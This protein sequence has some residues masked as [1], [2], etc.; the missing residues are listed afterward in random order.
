MWGFGYHQEYQQSL[1]AFSWSRSHANICH[2][3]LDW[4]PA[5]SL[6]ALFW[7]SCFGE[8]ALQYTHGDRGEQ[9]AAG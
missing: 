7:P 2:V 4:V 9:S 5:V 1:Q 3:Y 6:D 8:I